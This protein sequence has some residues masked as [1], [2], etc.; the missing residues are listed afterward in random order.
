LPKNFALIDILNLEN[1]LEEKYIAIDI[2]KLNISKEVDDL[3]TL[4]AKIKN[5][6][7]LISDYY[8]DQIEKI[9]KYRDKILDFNKKLALSL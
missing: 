4:I 6:N 7:K 8:G 5:E 3:F 1:S 2:S 9:K